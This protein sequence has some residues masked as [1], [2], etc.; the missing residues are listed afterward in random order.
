MSLGRYILAFLIFKGYFL[1]QEEEN[2]KCMACSELFEGC[3]E[4]S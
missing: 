3:L 4:C 1:I 2:N